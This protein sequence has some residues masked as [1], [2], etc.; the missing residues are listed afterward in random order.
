MDFELT[1]LNQA[2]KIIHLYQ[3]N[4]G[5]RKG[6]KMAKCP[7]GRHKWGKWQEK[8]NPAGGTGSRIR[9][10]LICPAKEVRKKNGKK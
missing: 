2:V 3:L 8:K 9:R 5:R 6:S 1:N 4:K 10:C 7:D